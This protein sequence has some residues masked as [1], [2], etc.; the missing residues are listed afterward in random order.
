M[1]LLI[2]MI[3]FSVI[4]CGYRWLDLVS[5]FNEKE[6]NGYAG[7]LGRPIVGVN[8]KC[9]VEFRIHLLGKT[10]WE[11]ETTGTAGDFISQIDG[12]T[13]KGKEYKVYAISKWLPLVTEYNIDESY[14]YSGYAGQFRYPISGLM[15]KD[16]I[17]TVAISVNSD[18]KDKSEQDIIN[19]RTGYRWL[20]FVS[21]FNE[22]A[23]K[24]KAGVLDKPIV[25][26][27]IAGG[28]KFMVH[29]LGK[30]YWEDE[31]IGTAGDLKTPID[32]I[33]IKGK[34]YKAYTKSH[35]QPLVAEYNIDES[36]PYPGYAGILT[37]PISGLMIKDCTY[38]VAILDNSTSIYNSGQVFVNNGTGV[39]DISYHY[40]L[41]YMEEGCYFMACCVIGGLGNDKQILSAYSWAKDLGYINEKAFLIN[42]DK[43]SLSKKISEIFGTNYHFNWKIQDNNC[44]HH[45][46]IDEKGKE[47]FNAA[48]L[49][50]KDC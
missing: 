26:V 47:V 10:S 7:I 9:G 35:W 30:N 39:K 41:T 36:Y 2:V 23:D 42:I 12:I 50:Y 24:V 11:D 6:D 14:K 3:L 45:W 28:I 37:N 25:G 31:V 34:E 18:P 49:N 48:G 20:P 40:N 21:G 15:I 19:N 16:C 29:L 32:G 27:R 22:N 8:I 13:I 4:V 44:F 46:V 5:G 1:K 38:T 33:A 17:Y 43:A